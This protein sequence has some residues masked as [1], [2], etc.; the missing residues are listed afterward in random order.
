[1]TKDEVPVSAV[2]AQRAPTLLS[3]APST[4]R[5]RYSGWITTV[6]HAVLIGLGILFL[7]P[8]LWMV[9]TSLKSLPQ[10][11]TWPPQWIPNPFVWANY[12]QA[13]TYFPFFRYL[14]N[15]VYYGITT[16]VGVLFSST[17]VAYGFS[18][19]EWRGRNFMFMVMIA[20]LM[21]PFQVVMI[22]LFILFRHLGWIGTY[23]PLIV[24][25]YLGSSVFSTFLLR[26][27]FLTIPQSLSDAARMDGAG[28]LTI[29]WRIILPL[30]KPALATV[31]LF[32]FLYCWND[33]LG[34]LIYINSQ[35]LYP[36]SLGLNSFLTSYG[37]TQWGLLMAAATVA[38]I[39]I[40]ILFFFAQRTFIQG[41]TLTG[42]KG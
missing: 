12:P 3:S 31:A 10:I 8:F 25:T 9:S 20:T 28:E 38:T 32:Q 39:P 30:S 36:I 6:R 42:I 23:D 26:Q 29:Y 5:R 21:L 19:L 2:P 4:R 17:L 35:N 22:P 14:W 40:V 18:R 41:I 15:T 7:I 13:L 1:M 16:V 34:P 24:P 33:F 37:L 11:L 27:F